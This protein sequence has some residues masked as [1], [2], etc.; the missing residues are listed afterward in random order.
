MKKRSLLIVDDEENIIKTMIRTLRDDGY[1]ILSALSGAEGLLRLKGHAV[2]LVISD[3]KM[4]GMS[5]LEFLKK[6]RVN[7]PHILCI[8][9]TAY[10]DIQTALAAI[11]DVG[12]YKFILKPW[13]QIDLRVTI[14]RALE[15]RELTLERDSLLGQVKAQE[16]ILRE[17]EKKHPG[18]TKVEKDDQGT[19]ILQL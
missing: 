8:I 17:L 4:P 3:Q 16:I 13:D 19:T 12:I 14:K 7:Y 11:N 5:G 10:G 6:V 18:I 2:D 1:Q 15:S 9:L